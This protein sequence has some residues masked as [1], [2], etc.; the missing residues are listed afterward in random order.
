MTAVN[1]GLRRSFIAALDVGG[2]LPCTFPVQASSSAGAGW[3]RRAVR[4]CH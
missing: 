1:T 3:A 4:Q 2:V